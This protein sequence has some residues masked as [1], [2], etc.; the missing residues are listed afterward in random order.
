MAAIPG[1]TPGILLN[2]TSNLWSPKVTF[3]YANAAARTGA[4]GLTSEDVAKTA[5]QI[6]TGTYWLLVDTIPTWIQLQTGTPGPA[7]P[8]WHTL[9]DV[10]FTA[11]ASQ[12]LASDGTYTIAGIT[13]TKV[14]SAKQGSSYSWEIVA[15]SGLR[16]TCGDTASG[17][18][19]NDL[20]FPAMWPTLLL[21]T[22]T[23]LTNPPIR[24]S[25]IL[26]ANKSSIAG[27]IVLAIGVEARDSTTRVRQMAQKEIG[28][29]TNGPWIATYARGA[30]G[31]SE[32]TTLLADSNTLMLYCP[33]GLLSDSIFV[34]VANSTGN[35]FPTS[36]G[37]AYNCVAKGSGVVTV[38]AN[39]NIASTS[40]DNWRCPISTNRYI[41][42]F[43]TRYRIEAY[44]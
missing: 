41:N 14:G 26:G 35:A 28:T 15:G 1:T 31:S 37:T 5:L 17:F 16:A 9:L 44:Y 10:D 13:W 6:D 27:Y 42:C 36:F 30:S 11:E 23:G 19:T 40:V 25:A 12:S 24:I 18:D 38:A 32:T 39:T 20:S 4:T 22:L 34:Y 3:S 29:V 7:G 8:M 33:S 21:G 43:V 2:S